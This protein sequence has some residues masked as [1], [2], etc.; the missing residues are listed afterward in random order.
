M[1]NKYVIN[2]TLMVL[3]TAFFTITIG[4]SLSWLVVAY[5]F[6]GRKLLNWALVLPIA[7][8]PYIGAYAYN[9]IFDY[10]GVVQVFLREAFNFEK[11]IK[12]FNIMNIRGAIFI[13]T[14]FLFP[15][16][17]IV[18]KSFLE[19]QSSSIVESAK[20]LGRGSVDIFFN[21]VIPI[22]RVAIIGGVSLV[23]LEVLNDYGVV[24]Y[25]GVPA[26]STGI[27]QIWFSM[28]DINSA[29]RLAAV[30]MIFVIAILFFERIIRG[31]KKYSNTNS[32]VTP[33]SRS[34]L[35]GKLAFFASFYG[36]S[37]LSL[38]FFIPVAQLFRWL[39]M[40]INRNVRLDLLELTMNSLL[41][42]FI[43]TILIV[44]SALIV[45]NFTRITNNS[46]SKLYAKITIV[47][48]SI[49]ASV[50][51]L[52]VIVFFLYLDRNL[53]GFLR[54]LSPDVKKL[55]LS[56]SL[57]MLIFAYYIRF[58]GIG[59]NAI[60]AGYEKVGNK[61]FESSRMLGESIFKTFYK[62]DM[63]MIK[64]AIIS[65]SILVFVDILKELPLTLILRPFNFDTFSTRAFEYANDEML[66]EASVASLIIIFISTIAIY[67]FYKIGSKGDEKWN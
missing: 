20:I 53:H 38:G 12:F 34:K 10:T 9:G 49:P 52:G 67:L 21:I 54:I 46:I 36:F 32:K 28:G 4:I 57:A 16:I 37:I 7:I 31:R 1:L 26:F 30:L 19:K 62:V 41:V 3:F 17:F 51:A 29:I 13:F 8:P 27:F 60:E 22:S 43:A 59:F 18:T 66:Q 39:S 42:A 58:L 24:K 11:G 35:K 23:I 2:S 40:T 6:P 63:P 55:F 25:F 15:Y 45:A 48:Y 65:G 47:G 50:I 14:I 61:F 5:D 56:S 33:L 44:I 64:G